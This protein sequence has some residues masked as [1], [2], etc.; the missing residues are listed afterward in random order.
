MKKLLLASLS[1]LMLAGTATYASDALGSGFGSLS[2]AQTI[3]MGRGYFGGGVGIADATSAFGSFTYGLSAHTD[4]R[5]KLGVIDN[6]NVN[7]S[8]FLGADFKYQFVDANSNGP[9]DMAA[10]AFTEYYNQSGFS[11]FTLGGQYLGSYPF[12]MTNGTTLVP[13]G[14]FNMR[15]ERKSFD[16]PLIDSKTDLQFG[17]N[18]GVQWQVNQDINLYG[19]FQLDGND[20][21]FFGI[22]FRTM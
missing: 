5:L 22:D 13:Y 10:G 11:D 1:I 18:G 15:L 4:G 3:G 9:F 19:E 7:A 2:T 6:S 16:S 21:I 14:R 20:G 8:L 17:L 12:K